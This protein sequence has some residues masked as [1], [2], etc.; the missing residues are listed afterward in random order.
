MT[1]DMVQELLSKKTLTSNGEKNN[2]NGHWR[3]RKRER[4][5]MHLS[6]LCSRA[7]NNKKASLSLQ[8]GEGKWNEEKAHTSMLYMERR[9]VLECC[10][11]R[12]V[13]TVRMY[14]RTIRTYFSSR[15]P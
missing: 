9:A 2:E 3:S 8:W 5:P 14:I 12:R 6:R 11:A 13:R 10:A 15:S 7:D 4:E 1:L